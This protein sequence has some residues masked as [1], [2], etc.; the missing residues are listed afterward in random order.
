MNSEDEKQWNPFEEEDM[1]ENVSKAFEQLQKNPDKWMKKMQEEIDDS[2]SEEEDNEKEEESEEE[3]NEESEN[4]EEKIEEEESEQEEEE[5]NDDHTEQNNSEHTSEEESEPETPVN[6][7]EVK[8]QQKR[9]QLKEQKQ[10]EKK[11]VKAINPDLSMSSLALSFISSFV[12]NVSFDYQ[13]DSFRTLF[14]DCGAI[15]MLFM[16]HRNDGR[17]AGYG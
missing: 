15:S 14:K 17:F 12:K 3:E 4:E 9:E 5:P 13:E 1:D 11:A 8:K 7:K 10:E 16:V 6:E 2:E